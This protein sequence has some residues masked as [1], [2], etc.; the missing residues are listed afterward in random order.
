MRAAAV[1]LNSTGDTE[2]NLASADRLVR[3]AFQRG[4]ELVVLPEKWS[5]LGT[6]EELAAG[7]QALDGPAISWARSVARETGIDLIAGSI[8][9]RVPGQE[10]TRNTSVH[11]APDGELRAIYR[12]LHM[13]DV[14]VEDT[15]YAESAHEQ[16]GDQVVLSEL[17]GGVPVG[18]S[19]CYDLRFPELYRMLSARGAAVI[20]VPSAFTVATTRDH[21][22]ILLRARAIENQCFVVAA[23]QF[24]SHGG[25]YRSGGRSMIVD[26]WGLVLAS[27]PDSEAVILADLDLAALKTIRR[28]F[29]ALSHRRE[30]V[31]GFA[32]ATPDPAGAS[33]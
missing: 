9:E 12:K 1:Q 2:R 21:W 29:P 23:N 14:E 5:V 4:A 31:Y 10:K 7:A 15:L 8:V 11:I 32:A 28:R 26:P 18:M 16:P 20:S 33:R 22:G 25:G 27:A 13:F 19:I 3:E 24:G 30:D 17:A 6:A